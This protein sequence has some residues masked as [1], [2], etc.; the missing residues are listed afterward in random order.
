MLRTTFIFCIVMCFISNK[1]FSQEK[2][3][4]VLLNGQTLIGNVQYA[5]LGNMTIDDVDLKMQNVKLYKIKKLVI[6]E[7]LR[8]ETI[9]KKFYYG[10]LK[11]AGKEGW[12]DIHTAL[13][14][15]VSILITHIYELISLQGGFFKRLKGNISAG[16]S[17]NKSSD[18][19]QLNFGANVMYSTKSLDYQLMENSIG[20]IDSGKFSSDNINVQLFSDYALTETWFIVAGLQ[21]QRNLELSIARRYLGLAGM[22]N[23]L[24]IKRNWRL[25]ALT[26]I[27]FSQEKSIEEVSSGLLYEIPLMFQFNFYQF[28]HPDIQISSTQAVYFSLSQP[29]RV[30]YDGNT[31]FSWQIIRYFYL[32]LSPY[33]NF[34]S[35]P[36][37]GNNS[38]FD[39]GVVFGISY[40]F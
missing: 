26:G 40:K 6:R 39:Y 23:Q 12:V 24:F 1:S 25:Q 32:N 11:S 31:S 38:T 20:T 33:T 29:G 30:R 15:T 16:F 37:A 5:D 18:I 17:F 2:D 19:G 27:T 22:G 9:E 14:D 7:N 10:S 8:I 35:K 28:R 3:T 4:I 21:I 34:D 13:G 36:P